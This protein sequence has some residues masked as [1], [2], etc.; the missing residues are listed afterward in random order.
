MRMRAFRG[1]FGLAQGRLAN[2][3]AQISLGFVRDRLSLSPRG[4]LG[5]IFR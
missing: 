5:M 3:R 4:W 2:G 1:P